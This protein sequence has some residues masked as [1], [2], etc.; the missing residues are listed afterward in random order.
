M[1][2][3]PEDWVFIGVGHSE[4]QDDGVGPYIA[5]ALGRHGLTAVAHQGD[6]SGLLELWDAR[7]RCVVID[8][9][10][11]GGAPGTVHLFRDLGDPA[12]AGAGFVHSTHQ[13]GLPEAV[14]LGRALGRLPERLMVIGITGTTFGFGSALSPPVAEAAEQLIDR[15]AGGMD[16][17][18]AGPG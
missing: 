14:A 11:G 3:V 1:S 15:L 10:A 9:V 6:G 13:I 18:S 2:S 4:R 7:Q 17:F 16:P 5:D 8:A 12:F